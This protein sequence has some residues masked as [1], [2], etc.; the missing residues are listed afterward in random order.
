MAIECD[1]Y[2][3]VHC[4]LFTMADIPLYKTISA[5]EK[6]LDKV[7]T[8]LGLLFVP[9]GILA[10]I[11]GA[12]PGDAV[13]DAKP[14]LR[15]MESEPEQNVARFYQ[16][17]KDALSDKEMEDYSINA[18]QTVATPLIMDFDIGGKVNKLRAQAD[19]LQAAI[20]QFQT[21]DVKPTKFLPFM[22]LDPRRIYAND[23]MESILKLMEDYA[24][25]S[26]DN[27]DNANNGDFI[28]IKLYPPLG[29]NV[30]PD[31]PEKREKHLELYKFFRE[32]NLPITAHCQMDS[33]ELT[34]SESDTKRYTSPKNWEKVLEKIPD[35]RI[36]FAH[37]GGEKGISGAIE[38]EKQSS[39]N[40]YMYKNTFLRYENL[41]WTGRIVQMLKKYKNTYAD[42][43]AFDFI[44]DERAT[45]SLLWLLARDKEGMLGEGKYHLED[46]LLWGSDYPMPLPQKKVSNYCDILRPFISTFKDSKTRKEAKFA[47]PKPES[48][49][50]DMK[51]FIKKLICDN[52]KAFLG[53]DRR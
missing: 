49:P 21:D 17:L 44:G 10:R 23:G 13:D 43:S 12:D 34:D 19:R 1:V 37:F 35:L 2:F 27:L 11:L 7:G 50:D 42:I 30:W 32:R 25:K 52:P 41:T 33:F 8:Y 40:T 9:L 22:G 3:D 20:K 16:E 28:G 38:F 45:A 15:F 4:H 14:F 26:I 29:A 46:K 6:H 39:N 31:S 48:L 47:R 18:G 36:N 51:V 53:L 24:V 5:K